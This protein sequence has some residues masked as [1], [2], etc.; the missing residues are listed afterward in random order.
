MKSLLTICFVLFTSQLYLHGQ[1]KAEVKE[2]EKAATEKSDD[3]KSKDDKEKKE[4]EKSISDVVKACKK[5]EGLFTFY[6][7]TTTGKAYMQ[8]LANQLDKEFIHFFHVE[9]GALDAGWVK[10]SYG[11][12][13]LFKIQKYYDRLE[14]IG[15]NFN[16]YFDPNDP[17]SRSSKA[18]INEP[19]IHIAKL[20]AKSIDLDSFLIEADPIMLSEAF[21][22]IKYVPE[23][24][25]NEK[26][27]F[28]LGN[29]NKEKS[30][31]DR[32]RSYPMNS[33][34]LVTYVFENP[35]PT[36]FGAPTITDPRY[37][38]IQVQQSFIQMPENDFVPRYDDPRV[39]Y[40][41]TQ[42]DDQISTDVTPYRDVIH[43][44]HLKKKN[45]GQPLSE[46]V[47]PITFWMEN[48]T[49]TELRPIIKKAVE[50]WN[51]A[52]EKAGFKNAVVVKQQPD[53]ADWDAGDLRYN[54]LRWTA[55]PYMGSAWGPS[56]VNPR[57]G[58]ILG[59]DIMLDYV[60]L[61]GMP[62]LDKLFGSS[63]KTLEEMMY[64][65]DT[66]HSHKPGGRHM[67]CEASLYA[68]EQY[69]FGR[70]VGKA[71]SFDD[72]EMKRM[73]EESITELLLH[74][75]GHTLGLNHNFRSSQLWSPEEVHNRSLTEKEGLTGSVMDYNPFNFAPTKEAQG[76]Y[77][78]LVP[79]PYDRWAIEYG[80]SEALA[81]KEAEKQRLQKILMRSSEPQLT[82]G[83][84][85]DAMY[86]PGWGIDP[87]IIVWDMS[88]DML[89]WGSQRIELCKRT[90]E[91]LHDKLLE[92]GESYQEFRNGYYTT[93]YQYFS[94]LNII[95][96]YIGGVTIN[97]AMYGQTEG[98]IPYVPVDYATQKKAMNILAKYAFA[99]DAF[100][101]PE[102]IYSFL[103]PQRRG[104]D[105]FGSTE[106]P[107]IHTQI[108]S[109]QR[110]FLAQLLHP[111]VMRRITDSGL[112]G[113]AYSLQSV[114]SDLTNSI[115]HTDLKTNVNTPRQNLQIEYVQALLS[116]IKSGRYDHVAE[117]N[118]LSQLMKIKKMMKD[119]KSKDAGTKA[120]RDHISYVINKELDLED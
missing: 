89:T 21:T 23:P 52:F 4:K 114:L 100:M 86:V 101:A 2:S 82:F 59:A 70:Y 30:R 111:T 73:T 53:D 91:Q 28:N 96:L 94:S 83:N 15:Q 79:G 88:N 36:N 14:F 13:T 104:F 108:G 27:P 17:L 63:T 11:F 90:L 43:R 41:N 7:D 115:F 61:R 6:Q 20:S 117:S 29:L 32:I 54:V 49:P 19:I 109:F 118:M 99:P 87:T 22:Q 5:I 44:W 81:D 65:G 97:R 95:S 35:Y 37:T 42:V 62:T 67:Y 3:D 45:P 98:A 25:S 78:S 93:M 74:E 39:G 9:N 48:T 31:I 103:Q 51:I 57:T 18:N 12:E 110:A 47:E 24:G 34:W 56:F 68:R 8:I 55:T 58:Q 112:Y 16:F 113:N 75:V 84:D 85:A 60:F 102:G 76:N 10:G 120:H 92:K 106:D 66:F 71:L 46:P 116:G 64:E 119:N 77:Q 105:F 26:N 33:D 72:E 69:A 40:F 80:Y 107:K 50:N 1:S 38:S